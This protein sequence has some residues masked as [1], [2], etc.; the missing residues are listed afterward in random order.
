MHAPTDARDYQ[1]SVTHPLK[2]YHPGNV[3]LFSV[4]DTSRHANDYL[5]AKIGTPTD[6]WQLPKLSVLAH[7]KF[8]V[9][10]TP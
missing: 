7:T 5:I 6:M 9:Y 4:P 1:T 8:E 3:Y 10:G 2:T